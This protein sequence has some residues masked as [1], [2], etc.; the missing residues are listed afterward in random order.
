MGAYFCRRLRCLW[1][2]QGLG[3]SSGYFKAYNGQCLSLSRDDWHISV[4]ISFKESHKWSPC[5]P[6]SR[7]P[8]GSLH[9]CKSVY[10]LD[11]FPFTRNY[12]FIFVQISNRWNY[13]MGRWSLFR[14]QSGC[15]CLRMI[16]RDCLSIWRQRNFIKDNLKV[17]LSVFD[18]NSI[19]GRA[20]FITSSVFQVIMSS[21]WVCSFIFNIPLLL[22]SGVDEES[23]NSYMAL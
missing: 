11:C 5:E 16:L 6:S 22:F 3:F 23:G 10:H 20:S 15:Y 17:W 9:G 12:W 19:G 2:E 21:S 1:T 13:C 14:D 8:V 7:H 18:F 4:W